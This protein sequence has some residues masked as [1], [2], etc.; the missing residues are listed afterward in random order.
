MSKPT[1]P[2]PLRQS[3]E[4][5]DGRAVAFTFTGPDLLGYEITPPPQFSD[6]SEALAFLSAYIAARRQFI[7]IIASVTGLTVAVVDELP[8]GV[9]AISE[10]IAPKGRQ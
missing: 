2:A 1:P 3:F 8:D 4:L 5:P 10:P 7:E 9:S 6:R